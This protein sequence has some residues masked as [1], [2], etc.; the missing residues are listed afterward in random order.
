VHKKKVLVIDD[1]R[2]FLGVASHM[3]IKLGVELEPIVAEDAKNGL[4]MASTHNPDLILL[5]WHLP[6]MDGVS[7]TKQ[8]KSNTLTRQIPIILISALN[9]Y[10]PDRVNLTQL[11]CTCFLSKPFEP[12]EFKYRIKST[13]QIN[14]YAN[15]DNKVFDS[16]PHEPEYLK[17][18]I[19]TI[20]HP[21]AV[22]NPKGVC[23]FVNSG[24]INTYSRQFADNNFIFYNIFSKSET[25][26]QRIID[27][28]IFRQALKFAE[29]EATI[30]DDNKSIEAKNLLITKVPFGDNPA[31]VSHIIAVIRDI[32]LIKKDHRNSLEEQ[33]RE[34]AFQNIKLLQITEYSQNLIKE[35][36]SLSKYMNKEG[37][38]ALEE[39]SSSYNFSVYDN[40][41]HEIEN[42]FSLINDEFIRKL[43]T[44]H[45]NLTTLE[46]KLC[47]YLKLNLST[48]Q[49]ALL[50]F[51]N[52]KS[53]EMARY[54]LRRKMN[55][56][57]GDSLSAYL[58]NL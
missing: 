39:I 42:Q 49:I 18:I 56:S 40:I 43:N 11:G 53:I 34:L 41:W 2:N 44:E 45:P 8:L 14:G 38:E 32:G 30:I 7:V 23:S 33:K 51:S 50:T 24:F 13:L 37:K 25:K 35:I 52:E 16:I 3:L 20:P 15:N 55:I 6:D 12:Q 27:K 21:I 36:T 47:F 31:K 46:R 29:H 57:N 19:N 28:D 1:D 10:A 9:N 48:K 58:T 22:Y 5:D 17:Q 54:R 26:K 4:L